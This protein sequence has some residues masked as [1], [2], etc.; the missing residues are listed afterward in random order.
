[1]FRK[2]KSLVI[3][4]VAA[5]ALVPTGATATGAG[6]RMAACQAKSLGTHHHIG[7]FVAIFGAYAPAN[8]LDVQMTCGVVQ[9]GVTVA[10]VT[11]PLPGPVAA[12][13]DVQILGRSWV[14]SCQEITVTRLD[15]TTT[16]TD[17][18]P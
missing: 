6:T 5:T 17:T 10:R 8:A 9:N 12:V 15:G 14:T 13:A 16:Q 1:M 4:A 2:S 11:D 3:A 7:Q 18:C